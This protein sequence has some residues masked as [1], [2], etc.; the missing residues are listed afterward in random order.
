MT[1]AYGD[2]ASLTDGTRTTTYSRLRPGQSAREPDRNAE[3]L[4]Q[5]G[6]G[7]GGTLGHADDRPSRLTGETTGAG[8]PPSRYDAG[9][10]RASPTRGDA[11]G[12]DGGADRLAAVGAVARSDRRYLTNR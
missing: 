4:A 1:V 8:A 11:T 9:G 3:T 12:A 7:S 6:G 10:H 2:R 5:V